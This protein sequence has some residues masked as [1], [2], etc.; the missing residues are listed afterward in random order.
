[1]A[2]NRRNRNQQRR[3]G[4]PQ[5]RPQP[6]RGG[7]TDYDDDGYHYEYY[8]GPPGGVH[9]F[10]E[11]PKIGVWRMVEL[12]AVGMYVWVMLLREYLIDLLYPTKAQQ[13]ARRTWQDY[14]RRKQQ[15]EEW[16]RGGWDNEEGADGGRWGDSGVQE[17][18]EDK[19]PPPH[20]VLGVSEDASEKEIRSA[21]KKKALIL[22]PDKNPGKEEWA[23]KQFHAL[24][25]AHEEMMKRINAKRAAET[26]NDS[27]DNDNENNETGE[28]DTPNNETDQDGPSGAASPRERARE[29]KKKR[30]EAEREFERQCK[31]ED[32]RLKQAKAQ[33]AREEAEGSSSA[34]GLA[35]GWDGSSHGLYSE[36][37]S[38]GHLQAIIREDCL[39]LFV[40]MLVDQVLVDQE[41]VESLASFLTQDLGRGST[42]LHFCAFFG[43]IFIAGR[44][45]Q[46]AQQLTDM[47]VE[48]LL[49]K[50]LIMQKNQDG[51]TP[52]EVAKE[53]FGDA[54]H[55]SDGHCLMVRLQTLQEHIEKVEEGK[56]RRIDWRGIM[57]VVCTILVAL[58]L[59]LHLPY[60][61]GWRPTVTVAIA[62]CAWGGSAVVL[63]GCALWVV[64]YCMA[65][66][67][68]LAI[69]LVCEYW[70]VAIGLCCEYWWQAILGAVVVVGVI[71]NL[72]INV[73]NMSG[74]VVWVVEVGLHAVTA[75]L[76]VFKRADTLCIKFIELM[77]VWDWLVW[78][79]RTAKSSLTRLS[80][81]CYPTTS[82][83]TSSTVSSLP[84]SPSQL[85]IADDTR[86]PT[87]HSSSAQQLPIKTR[88]SKWLLS[89]LIDALSCV[90]SCLSM[91]SALFFRL[92]PRMPFRCKHLLTLAIVTVTLWK[93]GVVPG[94]NLAV[95]MP[96]MSSLS[97]L[98]SP[99][100][101]HFSPP[102]PSAYRSAHSRAAS[103]S[104]HQDDDD[105]EEEEED[106]F[107]DEDVGA[108]PT[109]APAPA[110][111][112]T[113][114]MQQEGAG[115][116]GSEGE[117]SAQPALADDDASE[118]HD[119]HH[120][121]DATTDDE[122]STPHRPSEPSPASHVVPDPADDTRSASES[123]APDVDESGESSA[124]D[125]W[126]AE[127]DE[128]DEFEDDGADAAAAIP[129]KPQHV[130]QSVR[131]PT[132][133][134]DSDGDSL[135]AKPPITPQPH[136]PSP[137]PPAESAADAA[138]AAADP[139][140]DPE[141]D[142]ES[143]DMDTETEEAA[144]DESPDLPMDAVTLTLLGIVIWVA[145]G[146]GWWLF[147]VK[148][149]P[150]DVD[151]PDQQQQQ[152]R[153]ETA[154]AAD[155]Q[156][157][158]GRPTAH[159]TPSST[160][161]RGQAE[162]RPSS[163]GRSSISA[164]PSPPKPS[165][166]PSA[167]PGDDSVHSETPT[168]TVASESAQPVR[169]AAAAAAKPATAPLSRN[170]KRKARKERKKAAA[171]GR[172]GEREGPAGTTLEAEAPS[173]GDMDEHE[174]GTQHE[175]E[176]AGSTTHPE[177][178]PVTAHD[179]AP[180]SPTIP[181]RS[182]Y[183]R[184]TSSPAQV[185]PPSTVEL[186]AGAPP[187]PNVAPPLPSPATPES[188]T[189]TPTMTPSRPSGR[190]WVPT[191]HRGHQQQQQQQPSDTQSRSPEPTTMSPSRGSRGLGRGLGVGVTIRPPPASITSVL[192]QNASHWG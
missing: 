145:L 117:E 30:K 121:E 148:A 180:A 24:G 12:W 28:Q 156:D 189:K 68:K 8:Y 72:E 103:E 171:T 115:D 175:E 150:D 75:V 50:T 187:R 186:P 25:R 97:Q 146:V 170:A 125:I 134:D 109:S 143:D 162:P 61:V 93:F 114:S 4:G 5:P 129:E 179:T 184:A 161:E 123:E 91:V 64:F 191:A 168:S 18:E 163:S 178:I 137:E 130:W 111:N 1:M 65:F 95:S 118:Q 141:A 176:P 3:Y 16:R 84:L 49:F 41:G 151:A 11:P 23:K 183:V 81:K 59:H 38:P 60:W 54:P 43:R 144:I 62:L 85:A 126:V 77:C 167:S 32:Q 119:H 2:R 139:G 108:A 92:D 66:I 7:R 22:H 46:L 86:P 17:E 136:E 20:E 87:P 83:S 133:D 185:L 174:E 6:R 26:T 19:G 51:Y 155:G 102:S 82:T 48:P 57:L 160:D 74:Q 15:E 101:S 53:R 124:E 67:G 181:T 39:H 96:S 116:E 58:A 107:F 79:V 158:A 63:G 159:Q 157:T 153:N 47:R 99:L 88:V 149:R 147:S 13:D 122:P 90:S 34:A 120:E 127:M 76:S 152:S 98:W 78:L 166:L 112:K 37:N 94:G 190:V 105:E 135:E 182:V 128:G 110:K 45:V 154:T 172:E 52:F 55:G 9:F 188:K 113:S 173:A 27:T 106:D 71:A 29:E 56:K 138:A 142:I 35:D 169:T 42:P 44:L 165:V 21:Y 70:C 80:G 140:A 33:R 14:Q 177:S 192:Q 132:D 10:T 73:M 36:Y 131:L 164:T 100:P 40:K 69:G 104:I 31:A 89:R